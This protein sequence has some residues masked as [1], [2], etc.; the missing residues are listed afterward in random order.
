M[1]LIQCPAGLR[2]RGDPTGAKRRGG[3]PERP[4]TARAWSGNQQTSLTQPKK[5]KTPQFK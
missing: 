1:K 3:S 4:R 5:R 2:G